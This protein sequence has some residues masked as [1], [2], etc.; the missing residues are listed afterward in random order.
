MRQQISFLL[1]FFIEEHSPVFGSPFPEQQS[2]ANYLDRKTRQIDTLI[3]K[4]QKL[5][6]LLKE[7]RAAIINQAV[8]KGLNPNVKLKDSGIEWLGEIPEHWDVKKLKY[9]GEIC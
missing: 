9:F 4:K 6:D 7:Q 1:S 8:T 3:G 2:I 5:I